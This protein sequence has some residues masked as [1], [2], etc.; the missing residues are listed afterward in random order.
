MMQTNVNIWI[1]KC[2]ALRCRTQRERPVVGAGGVGSIFLTVK[3]RNPARGSCPQNDVGQGER[4]K[5]KAKKKKGLRTEV[6]G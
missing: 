2:H 1:S 3:V 5:A 4:R 6:G